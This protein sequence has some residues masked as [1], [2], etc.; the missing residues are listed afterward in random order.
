MSKER[1]NLRHGKHA[2]TFR[3]PVLKLRYSQSI[4][5]RTTKMNDNKKRTGST[6]NPKRGLY[7]IVTRRLLL[8]L[9]VLCVQKK[10]S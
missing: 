4:L 7:N 9:E 5:I 2:Y 1:V 3:K 8:V 10:H 6:L